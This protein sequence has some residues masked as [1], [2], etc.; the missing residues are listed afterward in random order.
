MRHYYLFIVHDSLLTF[1]SVSPAKTLLQFHRYKKPFLHGSLFVLLL[2]LSGILLGQKVQFGGSVV[3]SVT[4]EALP[5]VSV[6]LDGTTY[7]VN[8]NLEG[9]FLFV[10]PKGRYKI[11]VRAS[12]YKPFSDSI[13][14]D[15]DIT[16]YKV[17]VKP[18]SMA[19][20]EI[21]IT[22]KA[23][24]P[25][26][27][28]IR[29]AIANRR[30][31]RFDK[32][33]AYEYEA[34]NKLVLTMDNVTDKFLS[35]K[36]V[37]NIG[38]EVQEIMGD[39][40]HSDS[41]KY[42]IAGFVSESVSRFYYNRPDQKKEEILAVQTSG[43]KGSEYNLL[44]SMLLQLDMYD[45]NVVIV[46]RTFLSP[47]ADGA[48]V[49]YDFFMLSVESYGQDTLYGIQVLPKRPYD[50]V[51]KGTIYIDNHR[52][53]I[54]RLDLVLNENPNVNF[55][56][57]I[58]IRQE[59]GE[60]DSFWVPTL[61]D[62]EVDFQNSVMKRKGGKGISIIGRSSSHI[63]NYK[64]NQPKDPKFFQQEVMEVMQGAESKDSTYWAEARKSPL[65]K[66]EQLGFA[67][68]DSLRSR[69]VLDF[70]IEATRLIGWGT[71]KRKYWEVG[72]YFYVIG[73]NQAEG[74]RSRCGFYTRPDFSNWFYFGGHLAYGFGDKRLKYQVETKFRLVR[75]PKLEL[76]LKR[77]YEV[78]QVGFENF[79]N[80]GTSLLQSSLR[81][82]PLTQLNYYGENRVDVY[83]DI[84]KG[85]SGDF[86]FRTKS[87]EP[88][89]TFAFGFERPDGGLGSEYSIAEVGADLRLSF[90]E[91]YITDSR[92]DRKYVGTKYPVFQLKYRHGFDGL[93]QGQYKYDAAEV[94]M[95]NFV[96]MGR[97]GW[98]RYDLRAGQVFGTLPFPSLHVFRGNM[99]WGYDRYGF[100]LMNYYEFVADRY[101]TFAGEQHFE[102]LI[103]NQLPLLR[104]LKWKEVLTCRLAWGSLTPA[105]QQLNDA[106]IPRL[107]G[108]FEHQQIKAPT[109]V[110]YLEAGAGLYNIFKV[111][112]VDAI[113]RLNYFD[114]SY[115]TD[116]GVPK[117][118]WGRFNNFG[119]RADFSITF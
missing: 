18:V 11:L 87:F 47:I 6:V 9:A 43:V 77:T 86:Y 33:E 20:D 104:K 7:G 12:G 14:I 27:R 50:P 108:S 30:Y 103:W 84:M 96:R 29:N 76:G 4:Q 118:N 26:H 75:K 8:T 113:W 10:V 35:S 32:I 16:D 66:S 46:D 64:I 61:L 88:A 45:N 63:Y 107:D 44:N 70:Y 2:G 34:Y 74:M 101:V 91:K 57:D 28:V 49:D 3:D 21:V 105:N 24:N 60:V 95:G 36:L 90:K 59:Y 39:S 65:D 67:L 68:V 117:A 81:R 5:L 82:V 62:I 22:S 109:K 112:R 58:R 23:V 53:A 111:L 80:N 83:T 85:L 54:N 48:F 102:G 79:L 40:T 106:L 51:F 19:L 119:L 114:L 15:G 17:Q 31:N 89:R 41:T 99:S 37:R 94:Q 13:T 72:P 92:G 115:K 100:N 73:F 93:L 97:Y 116:P 1:A 55:V 110:P 52:W 25:A 56:E 38:K 98:F 71:Y 69:G 78:E 42:K